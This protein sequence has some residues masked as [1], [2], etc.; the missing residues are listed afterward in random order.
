MFYM[1]QGSTQNK[2]VEAN[3]SIKTTSKS[4]HE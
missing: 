2:A 4:Q 3:K 1:P